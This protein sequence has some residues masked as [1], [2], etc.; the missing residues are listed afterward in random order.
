MSG[1]TDPSQDRGPAEPVTEELDRTQL[2]TSTANTPRPGVGR[3]AAA[4][5]P[6]VDDRGGLTIDDVVVEKVAVAAAAEV[7]HVGGAARRVLGVPTGRSDGDGRARVSARVAGGTAALAV[8]LT[9]SYPASVRS[10]TEAA[11]AHITDRVQ[12]LTELRVTRVDIDVAALTVPSS[13]PAGRVIA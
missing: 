5:G 1:P 10:V 6:D 9:V 11:R 13:A 12:A 7:D 8:R 4:A 2:V 3:H